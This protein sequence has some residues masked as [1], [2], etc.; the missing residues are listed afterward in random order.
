MLSICYF[1]TLSLRSKQNMDLLKG[2]IE[3]NDFEEIFVDLN[4]RQPFS[5]EEAVRFALKQATIV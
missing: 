2:I 3:S 1:G 5:T 4:I